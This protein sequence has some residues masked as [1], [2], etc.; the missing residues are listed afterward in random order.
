MV[1]SRSSEAGWIAGAAL[2]SGRR[3][4]VWSVTPTFARTLVHLWTEL[5]ATGDAMPDA[6]PLGYRGCFLR[7][8]GG[9]E[10][11]AYRGVVEGPSDA[12]REV[13]LDR[14]RAFERLLV[15]SAPPRLL[16]T[17]LGIDDL[18]SHDR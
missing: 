17:D 1:T 7:S 16:P 5:P 6:P 15:G 10:W 11:R 13:R 2:F 8:P 3:D 4:P 12:G 14:E 9:G 18:T